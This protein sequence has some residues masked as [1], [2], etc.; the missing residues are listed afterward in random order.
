MEDPNEAVF[1]KAMKLYK[2][3]YPLK[4]IESILQKEGC[5]E[6]LLTEALCKIKLISYK[7]RKGRGVTYMITGG[8]ILLIGFIM[9]VF[10]FHA[11]HD[12]DIFMYG[13]TIIG[14]LILGFGAYEVLQ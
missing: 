8:L 11:N 5:D 1:Q 7:K 6:I 2:E 10:L 12:F 3:G 14:T 13:F 4:S 9:T